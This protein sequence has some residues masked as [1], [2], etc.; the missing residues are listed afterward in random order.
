VQFSQRLLTPLSTTETSPI[1]SL[2]ESVTV[3]FLYTYPTL[4]EKLMPLLKSLCT[5]E[6]LR[7]IVTLRYHIPGFTPDRADEE[8]ELNLYTTLSTSLVRDA[9]RAC[10]APATSVAPS[11]P[12]DD[13][14]FEC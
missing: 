1:A 5:H 9:V 14:V 13:L 4:L 6:D 11:D 8:N 10:V 3:V 7:A 12:E 2:L